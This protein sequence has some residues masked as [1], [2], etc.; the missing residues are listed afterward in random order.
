MPFLSRQRRLRT[1]GRSLTL[2]GWLTL[3]LLDPAAGSSAASGC[4][5]KPV[6]ADPAAPFTRHLP[7][8]CTQEERAGHPVLAEE[9]L[10]AMKEGRGIDLAGVVVTGDLALD[11][12]PL[13]SVAALDALPPRFKQEIEARHLTEA[14]VIAGPISIR[15]SLVR[16]K[17]TTNLQ[18]GLLVVQ[19]PVTTG[20]TT[21]ER[22]VDFSLAVFQ[23]PVDFSDTVLL[24]EGFFIRALFLQPA[25]FERTAF[26]IHSR[27]HRA[28]FADSVTFLRAGFN[29]LS[30]FLEVG[31]EKEASFSRTYFK[32]GAGFS[33]SRFHGGLDFSEATFEREAFFLFTVF[34]GDAYFR[35]S[36]F[37]ATADFSDAVFKGLDDF[38][39]VFF[40]VPPNFTRAT[41][42]PDRKVLGGLQDPKVLYAIG[43]AIL[44]FTLGFIILLRKT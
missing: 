23:S 15:D 6:P 9:L 10:A 41:R 25:R 27:F 17:I 43:A 42:N 35:R 7:D 13:K 8:N 11:A 16:G 33:G 37:R 14:R 21:F 31:F 18:D 4:S 30:E 39:K 3:C 2:A 34:E 5:F 40:E 12:L 22:L 32:L 24:R 44:I 1:L 20:G 36:T 19:G 38:S 29:G 28:V 26:G